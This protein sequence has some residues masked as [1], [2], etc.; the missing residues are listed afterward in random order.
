LRRLFV[1]ATRVRARFNFGDF[2]VP[3][4]KI[5]PPEDASTLKSVGGI[6]RIGN[7]LRYSYQGFGHAIRHEA[8]FRQELLLVVPALLALPFF[9]LTP[10]ELVALIAT[11]LLVLIVELLNSAI[12][13]VVDRVSMERHPLAGR[14]KDLGSAAVF[15]SLTIF[16][17]CWAILLGPQILRLV[18]P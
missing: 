5:P 14:A 8:A 11:A 17:V 1:H 16:T 7:A 13:A 15:L 6:V 18:H 12:E 2:T 3:N 4:E 10:I 9:A